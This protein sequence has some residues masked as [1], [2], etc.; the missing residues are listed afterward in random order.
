MGRGP[1]VREP[2]EEESDPLVELP[3]V[4]VQVRIVG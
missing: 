1:A 3:N 4:S 2:G